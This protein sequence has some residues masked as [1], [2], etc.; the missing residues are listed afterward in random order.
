MPST[1]PTDSDGPLGHV[2]IV[3]DDE[4]IRDALC[5]LLRDEGYAVLAAGDGVEAMD[6]L[7]SSTQRMVVLLDLLMPRLSGLDVLTL[8]IEDA[9]LMTRHTF[10]VVTANKSAADSPSAVDP[11]FASLLDRHQIP[12]VSKPFNITTL[13]DLVARSAG[14]LT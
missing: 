10:I 13:L 8:V 12:V 1:P 7:L 5:E 9:E 2:L 3:D 4:D 11:Y 6:I 14:R